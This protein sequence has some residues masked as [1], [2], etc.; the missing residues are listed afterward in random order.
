MQQHLGTTAIRSEKDMTSILLAFSLLVS[1]SS[2]LPFPSAYQIRVRSHPQ[3]FLE[4]RLYSIVVVDLK[5]FI[6]QQ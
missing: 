1:S 5:V 6:Q 3:E 4:Q 2:S